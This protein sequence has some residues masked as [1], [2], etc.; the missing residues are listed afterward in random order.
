[1]TFSGDDASGNTGTVES[2]GVESEEAPAG[3]SGLE[4]LKA[5]EGQIAVQGVIGP[6]FGI[7]NLNNSHQLKIGAEGMYFLDQVGKGLA[8]GGAFHLSFIDF[9]IMQLVA[10]GGWAFPIIPEIYIM[11]HLSM[12]LGYIWTLF[13]DQAAF[14]LGFGVDAVASFGQFF[15]FVRPFHFDFLFQGNT[16]ARYDLLVGGGVSF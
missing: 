13:V 5:P 4:P 9:N 11:P 7:E 8:I 15:A 12:G 2:S 16:L 10:R 6:A 14:D 1:M 3:S